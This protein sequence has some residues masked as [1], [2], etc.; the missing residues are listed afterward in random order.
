VRKSIGVRIFTLI[1][2]VVVPL[3]RFGF[4]NSSKEKE[5]WTQEISDDL[6]Y[7]TSEAANKISDLFNES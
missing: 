5:R 7:A 1:A 2:A 4:Y 6:N 3:A